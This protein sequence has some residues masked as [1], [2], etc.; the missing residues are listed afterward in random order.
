MRWFAVWSYSRLFTFFD[1]CR[2]NISNDCVCCSLPI[3]KHNCHVMKQMALVVYLLLLVSFNNSNYYMLPLQESTYVKFFSQGK[4]L[5]EQL[6]ALCNQ[7][8]H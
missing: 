5:A 7:L 8:T 1:Q 3:H 4:H 2:R 6:L